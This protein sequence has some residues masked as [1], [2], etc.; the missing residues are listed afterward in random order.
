MGRQNGNRASDDTWNPSRGSGNGHNG[1]N[2]R[3]GVL[4][5]GAVMNW[6]IG[7]KG[8]CLNFIEE[9]HQYLIDGV[10]VP[11]I[12]QM[13]K[14]KFGKKYDGVSESVLY[15]AA[16][17]GTQMHEAIEGYV[18]FGAEDE[19]TELRNF[20]FLMKQYKM[21]PIASEIPVILFDGDEP[22]AAGRLDLVLERDGE[23]GLGDLKR[24]AVLDREYL[25]YQ[26]NLYRRAYQQCYDT[27]ISFLAGIHLREDKRKLIQLP[28]NDYIVDEIIAKEKDYEYYNFERETNPRP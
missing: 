23:K 8:H 18:T 22:I 20:K 16:E 24:T 17:R 2:V 6:T 5:V 26:L 25:A 4:S 28:I 1:R 9:T 13:L 12:T 7:L 27:K 15:K 10:E 21:S 11:S 19:S 3:S 14:L